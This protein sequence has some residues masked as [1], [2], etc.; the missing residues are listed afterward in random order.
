M[1]A[2]IARITKHNA[3]DFYNTMVQ[4]C[5]KLNKNDKVVEVLTHLAKHSIARN[6]GFCE[7]VMKQLAGARWFKEALQVYPILTSDGL[8]PSTVMCSCM[9]CFAADCGEHELAN[10]HYSRLCSLSTPNLRTCMTMLQVH[11][12][13]GDWQ[14]ALAVYR[15]MQVRKVKIDSHAMNMVMGICAAAGMACEVEQL[16][17]EAEAVVPDLV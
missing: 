3:L 13:R 15:D 5:V 7:G 8:E 9:I 1:I 14:A 6:I 2:E 16:L 11:S 10:H 17:A 12:Q 4:S